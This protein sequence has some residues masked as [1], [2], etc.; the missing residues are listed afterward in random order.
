[1]T[2]VQSSIRA[3]RVDIALTILRIVVGVVFIAHGAQKLFVWGHTGVMGGF[4]QMGIP[5]PALTSWAV[6]IVEFFG[7]IALV[8]GAATSIAAAL[9][10]I[11]M[12][13][14]MVFVHA[15]NGFFLPTGAEYAFTLFFAAIAIMIAG[16]GPWS[17]D[18]ALRRAR[19]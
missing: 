10:A 3:P 6:A 4:T 2:A 18:G 13:G 15:K 1:M 17:V 14:A 16:A 5:M 8:I 9:V 12:L 7:G 11:D 19:S